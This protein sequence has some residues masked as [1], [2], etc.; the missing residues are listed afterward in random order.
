MGIINKYNGI[1]ISGISTPPLLIEGN[2]KFFL[3]RS[4]SLYI[5]NINDI[6]KNA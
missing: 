3:A 6:I 4:L 5:S 1:L 2:E